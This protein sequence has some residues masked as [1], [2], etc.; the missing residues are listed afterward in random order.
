MPFEMLVGNQELWKSK[1][2]QAPCFPLTR[3]Y[4]NL[5]LTTF[6][7]SSV[8]TMPSSVLL[9]LLPTIFPLELR[10]VSLCGYATASSIFTL[11][12]DAAITC[13]DRILAQHQFT[14]FFLHHH[15]HGNGTAVTIVGLSQDLSIKKSFLLQRSV[16]FT[17]ESRSSYFLSSL[18]G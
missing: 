8:T 17:G 11:G 7:M 4:G 15:H 3:T 1:E 10:W 12:M 14:T 16:S 18:F 2:N 5:K 6:I 13:A 9:F